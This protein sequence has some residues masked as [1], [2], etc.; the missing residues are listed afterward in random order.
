MEDTQTKQIDLLNYCDRSM[1]EISEFIHANELAPKNTPNL[2][3]VWLEIFDSPGL[4]EFAALRELAIKQRH[5]FII[6]YSIETESSLIEAENFILTIAKI[7]DETADLDKNNTREIGRKIPMLL[8]GNKCDLEEH[9]K[10]TKEQGAALAEKYGILHF[11]ECSAK[12][13]TPNIDCAFGEMALMLYR[14]RI[15]QENMVDNKKAKKEC[16]VM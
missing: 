13:Y 8:L 16:Q 4:E 9:R 15:I 10:V 11:A 7:K 5:G 2:T 12:W 6:M 14:Q 3:N 1:P